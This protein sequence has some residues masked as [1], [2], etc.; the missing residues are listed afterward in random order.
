MLAAIQLGVADG[1]GRW[2][3]EKVEGGREEEEAQLGRLPT[4]HSPHCR[5][6]WKVS[7][8]LSFKLEQLL[9]QADHCTLSVLGGATCVGGGGGYVW[10]ASL[11][12]DWQRPLR[13]I[14]ASSSAVT[15]DS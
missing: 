10:E 1:R 8:Q 7:L 9:M 13:P 14:H 3:D 2:E 5:P 12:G 11:R 4:P 6:A 15:I